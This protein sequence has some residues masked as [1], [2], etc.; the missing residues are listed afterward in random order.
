[1]PEISCL[2]P[3]IW[4]YTN[5]NKTKIKEN[6]RSRKYKCTYISQNI[7]VQFEKSKGTKFIYFSFLMVLSLR[8]MTIHIYIMA[9]LKNITLCFMKHNLRV[10]VPLDS[11]HCYKFKEIYSE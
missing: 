3:Y 7:Y 10:Y 6:M 9:Y 4:K 2:T 5:G 1:M 8:L 11:F